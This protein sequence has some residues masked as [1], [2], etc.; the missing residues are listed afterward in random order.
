[1]GDPPNHAPED[2]DGQPDALDLL[3]E[4]DADPVTAPRNTPD[5]PIPPRPEDPD[6]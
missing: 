5:A 1:M 4:G 3:Y 6:A 2:T